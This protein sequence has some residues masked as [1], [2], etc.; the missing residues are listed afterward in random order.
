MRGRKRVLSCLSCHPYLYTIKKES[1]NEGTETA[2][3]KTETYE[4]V[5]PIK[6][7]SPNE[8][9]ETISAAAL[10]SLFLSYKKRIPEW[11][12]GNT[13]KRIKCICVSVQIKKESP[14]EGTETTVLMKPDE[15]CW[16]C[17]KKRIP[18]WGDGN[19]DFPVPHKS[20]LNLKIKKE[21]P[22]EGTETC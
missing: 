14:N 16:I 15:W 3:Y 2:F 6:K 1:P 8:G 11:G 18:E 20:V 19:A 21:S 9:T 12:D 4:Y 22:N 17:N 5:L 7:E 13:I 10:I